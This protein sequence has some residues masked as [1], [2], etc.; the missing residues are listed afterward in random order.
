MI[1]LYMF[2]VCV[3]IFNFSWGV[4]KKYGCFVYFRLIKLNLLWVKFLYGY[5]FK[6]Y[7]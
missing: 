7:F 3:V 2:F 1:V 5:F 4:F 6:K